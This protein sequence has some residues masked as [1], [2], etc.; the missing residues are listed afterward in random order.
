LGFAFRGGRWRRRMSVRAKAWS[1]SAKKFQP[2]TWTTSVRGTNAA[3]ED[4]V[5]YRVVDAKGAVVGRLATQLSTLLQGKH[6]PTYDPRTARGDVLVVVNARHVQFTQH[7]AMEK[8]LYKK[9]TRYPGGLNQRTAGQ[10]HDMDPTLLLRKAIWNMLPKNR[11]RMEKIKRLRIFPDAAHPWEGHPAGDRLVRWE[12]KYAKRDGSKGP[13]VREVLLVHETADGGVAK[14]E[15]LSEERIGGHAWERSQRLLP[16]AWDAVEAW[17]GATKEAREAMYRKAKAKAEARAAEARAAEAKAARVSRRAPVLPTSSLR[18][19]AARRAPKK[20]SPAEAKSLGFKD[21]DEDAFQR[22]KRT[23]KY[24][25][26]ER[27]AR[28]W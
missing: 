7:L 28:R 5:E 2:S 27:L 8:K 6:K 19:M 16:T 24:I 11:S 15:I 25:S 21:P 22:A 12:N 10:I 26:W 18:A 1:Y 13:R 9:H 17:R 20:L 14:A 4:G 3:M 23:Q